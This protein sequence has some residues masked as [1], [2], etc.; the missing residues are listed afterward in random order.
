MTGRALF[1]T[2][3]RCMEETLDECLL[4]LLNTTP[5]GR[6]PWVIS[7]VFGIIYEDVPARRQSFQ[8]IPS[9]KRRIVPYGEDVDHQL[10]TPIPL[11]M[12]V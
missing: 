7:A 10:I 8:V 3:M 2:T 5:S 12:P 11:V 9:F 6:C 4:F 1:P